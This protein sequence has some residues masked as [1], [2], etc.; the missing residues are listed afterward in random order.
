M[1]LSEQLMQASKQHAADAE[2]CKLLTWAALHIESQDEALAEARADWDAE[3][4]ERMRLESALHAS[5]NQVEEAL[6]GLREAWCPPVEL[7]RDY[8]PHINLM[9]AHGDPDYLRK[10]GQ[11]IRHVDCRKDSKTATKSRS[12][13]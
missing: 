3:A 6:R 5:G 11:S 12:K 8:V 9:A 10:S 4:N 2:L 13:K 7:G 1:S